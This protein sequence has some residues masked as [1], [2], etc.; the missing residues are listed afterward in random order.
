[1]KRLLHLLLLGA[2]F[3][4]LAQPVSPRRLEE[5]YD[6]LGTYQ[7]AKYRPERG[8]ELLTLR[9]NFSTDELTA[10]RL[11]KRQLVRVDLVYTAF[12]LDPTFGQRQ[13]NLGRFRNLATQIPGILDNPALSWRLVEQTGCPSANTC[14]GYFHGFVLYIEK[15]YTAAD[16][17][18]EADKLLAMLEARTK[19]FDKL[20]TARKDKGK[21]IACNYPQSRYTLKD[22]TKRLKRTYRPPGKE[23]QTLPFRAEIDH[24]GAV[25]R[26]VIPPEAGAETSQWEALA[27]KLQESFSFASGFVVGKQRLPFAVTGTVHLPLRRKSLRIAGYY[28]ADSVVRKYHIRMRSDDCVARFYKPGEPRDDEPLPDPDASVVSKV[29]DRHPEWGK[30]VVVADVTGSMAPYTLDFLTWLQLSA[31]QEEKTFVFFND[32]NDAPDNAKT[33]G[34]T[35][36]IYNVKTADFE[37]IKAKVLEAMRAGGGGDAPENDGEAIAHALRLRPDATEI[38]LLADNH[39]FPRDIRLLR[40]TR[41]KVRV[42]LCGAT[43]FVNPKYL[44]LAREYGYTLHTLENDITNLSTLLAGQ[45][46]N[47]MGLQY[48]VTEEGFKLVKVL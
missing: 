48:L 21:P 13:L 36:G 37:R 27:Q 10:L 15:R 35:G 23:A 5:F 41:V 25:Q 14:E 31:L 3:A 6:R 17:R 38:I 43:A 4:G 2:H 8:Y 32:G 16:T 39:T 24:T 40:N 30:Q 46:V 1:M 12:R 28:V 29:M 34:S 33:I 9:S 26:V 20:R 18:A 44:A 22:L 45:T 42:I 19:T 11:G 47:I 7:T